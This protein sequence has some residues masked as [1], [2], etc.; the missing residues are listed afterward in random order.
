MKTRDFGIFVGG[1]VVGGLASGF[2][3]IR[4]ALKSKHI[5]DCVM[6]IV[7]QKTSDIVFI[8]H[9]SYFDSRDVVFDDIEE[10]EDVL[11]QL[12][13]VLS[14]FGVVT[15][16]DFKDISG[17]ESTDRMDSKYGWI[18]F[19]GARIEKNSLGCRIVL[20]DVIRI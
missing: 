2:V 11:I 10:A 14:T 3:L 17:I 19:R 20:P 18:H 13:E 12:S 16:C 6:K 4:S 7:S 1:F 5:R 9:H 15:V 8:D